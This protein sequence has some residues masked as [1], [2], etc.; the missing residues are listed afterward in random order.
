MKF[1][2]LNMKINNTHCAV[3]LE[4]ALMRNAIYFASIYFFP[5]ELQVFI[6]HNTEPIA[7]IVRR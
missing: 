6:L 3:A 1:D 2:E 4:F 5:L 7:G